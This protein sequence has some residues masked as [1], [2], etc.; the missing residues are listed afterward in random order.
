VLLI[1]VWV[2]HEH[3]S[4]RRS[5]TIRKDDRTVFRLDGLQYALQYG[6]KVLRCHFLER[7]LIAGGE[8]VVEGRGFDGCVNG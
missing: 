4:Y 1:V 6:I 8:W 3:R 2:E 7:L 5:G